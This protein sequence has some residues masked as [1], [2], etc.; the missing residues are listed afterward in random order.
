MVVAGIDASLTTYANY[1]N[2][3]CQDNYNSFH[4]RSRYFNVLG[5][6]FY[7]RSE[8]RVKIFNDFAILLIKLGYQFIT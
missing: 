3:T 7:N 5:T 1:K 4:F 6:L 8:L 2:K